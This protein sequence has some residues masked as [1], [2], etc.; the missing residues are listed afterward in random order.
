M[1]ER[2][3]FALTYSQSAERNSS[4]LNDIAKEQLSPNK[5]FMLETF[6]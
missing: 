1:K 4:Q 2:N 5:K 3:S 6:K